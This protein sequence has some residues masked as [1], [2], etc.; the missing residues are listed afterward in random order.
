[1]D[2]PAAGIA[3]DDI[4]Q[5]FPMFRYKCCELA[6]IGFLSPGILF[7]DIVFLR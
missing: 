5:L 1:M 7:E 3:G 6:D 2:L 4:I